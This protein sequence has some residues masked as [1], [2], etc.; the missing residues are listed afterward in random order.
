[1]A[2][3]FQN[4]ENLNLN[5][6]GFFFKFLEVLNEYIGIWPNT[7]MCAKEILQLQIKKIK[8]RK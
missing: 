7:N 5:M 8:K 2:Y 3:L 1:M 4:W 6:M